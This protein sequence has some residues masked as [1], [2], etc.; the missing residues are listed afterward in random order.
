M[1]K[2]LT[3]GLVL[4]ASVVI[5]QNFRA[6]ALDTAAQQ[7]NAGFTA[8]RWLNVAYAGTTKVWFKFYDSATKPY[9]G[10]AK[11]ILTM[12][13][14]SSSSVSPEFSD[15]MN[16]KIFF[17]NGVWVRCVAGIQDTSIMNPTSKPILE[18]GY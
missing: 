1:K 8:L 15:D 17:K 14:S 11:P 16:G 10:S 3:L 18:V 13:V 12:Q 9:A 6:T 5:G 2:A 7:V 4:F